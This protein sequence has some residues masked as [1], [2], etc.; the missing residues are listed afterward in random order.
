MGKVVKYIIGKEDSHP[1]Y[2]GWTVE[3]NAD[4]KV[5]FHLKNMRMDFTIKA[6][7]QFYDIIK[8]INEQVK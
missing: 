8:E 6:Y 5:H 4:G 7:N 3:Q 2:E 1:K